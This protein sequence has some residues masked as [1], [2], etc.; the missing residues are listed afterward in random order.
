MNT[1][2]LSKQKLPLK[3]LVLKR[4]A[5]FGLLGTILVLGALTAGEARA[6]GPVVLQFTGSSGNLSGNTISLNDPALNGKTGLKL[7]ITQCYTGTYNAHP[8]GVYLVGSTWAAYNEDGD[9]IPAGA[10]FNVTVAP[11][12]TYATPMNSA[13]EYTELSV[14]K[15]NSNGL[16]FVTH[17]WNPFPKVGGTYVN[18]NQGVFYDIFLKKW[19]VFNE[20]ESPA[21]VAAY[22]VLDATKN[23]KAFKV[24][25]SVS[26]ID[27][28]DGVYID[29]SLTNGNPGAVVFVTPAGGTWDHPVG[30]FYNN[31]EWDIFNEDGTK[32]QAGLTFNVLAF[33][34]PNH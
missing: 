29:N 30:V 5:V 25:T 18:H 3:N 9:D 8:V 6:A 28:G 22:N 11:A 27:G 21:I 15:S 13:A 19:C 16:L 23:G 33:P 20:D 10:S 14:E 24:T 32:M 17:Y 34:G 1:S 26:N 12:T 2:H 4:G 7:I 31:G